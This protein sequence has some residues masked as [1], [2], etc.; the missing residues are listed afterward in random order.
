MN[1]QPQAGFEST[2]EDVDVD[3]G[4]NLEQ[5]CLVEL[6]F[7]ELLELFVFVLLIIGVLV[8]LIETLSFFFAFVFKSLLAFAS[9]LAM[10]LALGGS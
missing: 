5:D 2:A 9:V 7:L 8:S 4:H 10:A 1:E 3:E 6:G